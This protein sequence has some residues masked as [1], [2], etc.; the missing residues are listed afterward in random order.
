VGKELLL[1]YKPE[2]AEQVMFDWPKGYEDTKKA[3]E[4]QKKSAKPMPEKK[5]KLKE[6]QRLV[7]SKAEFMNHFNMNFKEE[8][9]TAKV[10]NYNVEAGPI[11]SAVAFNILESLIRFFVEEW[12]EIDYKELKQIILDLSK[13]YRFSKEEIEELLSD[14]PRD[15]EATKKAIEQQKI[16]SKPM[17]EKKFRLKE[18]TGDRPYSDFESRELYQCGESG[19]V[20]EKSNGELSHYLIGNVQKIPFDYKEGFR[21]FALRIQALHPN[22]ELYKDTDTMTDFIEA[23]INWKEFNH[24]EGYNLLLKIPDEET[25]SDFI[26]MAGREWPHF[27]YE[28]ALDDLIA[29]RK[30]NDIFIAGKHWPKFNYE[31]GRKALESFYKGKFGYWLEQANRFWPKGIKEI[32]AE[33]QQQKKN[34][35]PM[36]EKKF[37]LSQKDTKLINQKKEELRKT[38]G[39]NE[40]PPQ[41]P[42]NEARCDDVG[43]FYIPEP[44]GQKNL[45]EAI[46]EI[47]QK[48]KAQSPKKTHIFENDLTK[49]KKLLAESFDEKKLKVTPAWKIIFIGEKATKEEREYLLDHLIQRQKDYRNGL[50]RFVY[51]E[52]DEL[53]VEGRDDPIEQLIKA[54]WRWPDFNFKKLLDFVKD[55]MPKNYYNI[56]LKNIPRGYNETRKDIEVLKKSAIPMRP[57][58]FK[59]KEKK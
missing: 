40:I 28:K 42:K 47:G 24:K 14:L 32:K 35:K 52:Q 48:G 13:K 31:K 11:R 50:P 30:P 25:R 39:P 2:I 5:F 21:E 19:V 4:D 43:K 59:L 29:L 12:E 54:A 18:G 53:G 9:Y 51:D 36:P 7:Y 49:S 10:R 44:M 20:Y 3:I 45:S 57:K 38:H 1:K 33:I 27:D 8:I 34:S 6:D 16:R 15:Y 55:H 37:R 22:Y 46:Y 23:G 41:T 58:N 56:V 26:Q 17:P